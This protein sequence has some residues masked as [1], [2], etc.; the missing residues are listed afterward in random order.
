M[1]D[2][3]KEELEMEQIKAKHEA[4]VKAVKEALAGLPGVPSEDAIAEMKANH[5][6]IFVSAV[7][8]DMM[9]LFRSLTRLEYLGIRKELNEH[10]VAVQEGKAEPRDGLFEERVVE[11]CMLWGSKP[12]TLE[13]KAGTLEML[14]EQVMANSNFV[15]AATAV[16]MVV[17]L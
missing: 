8:D 4:F 12:E 1:S 3:S 2:K 13:T 7:D 15:N 17:K 5:G 9:F 6:D 16:S 14:F 11:T 10:A